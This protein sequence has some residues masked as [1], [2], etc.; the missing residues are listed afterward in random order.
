M[1]SDSY[2]EETNVELDKYNAI[3]RKYNGWRLM[4][5]VIYK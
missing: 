1:K 5:F 2:G 4:L 3:A